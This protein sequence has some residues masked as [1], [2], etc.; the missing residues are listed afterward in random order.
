MIHPYSVIRLALSV[1]SMRLNPKS[2]ESAHNSK[3]QRSLTQAYIPRSRFTPMFS[4][5][6]L[7]VCISQVL[8]FFWVFKRLSTPIC[9]VGYA[10][11]DS[12]H[13]WRDNERTQDKK[14][15]GRSLFLE[16]IILGDIFEWSLGSESLLFFCKD[17]KAII[18]N[19]ESAW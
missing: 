11:Y 13:S 14:F 17:N 1:F 5:Y 16:V 18:S 19:L 6:I 9:H 10:K 4:L 3:H 2:W 12:S 8:L 15:W 7:W